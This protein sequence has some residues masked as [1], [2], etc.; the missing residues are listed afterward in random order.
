MVRLIIGLK[1]S[2]KTKNLIDLTNKAVETSPGNVVCVEK[3]NKL[4][5]DI[6]REVRLVDTD[7]YD[8]CTA[9]GLYGLICGIMASNYDVKDVFV[10]SGLRIIGADMDGF[11]KLI[12]RLDVL[13]G[14]HEVNL[15]CTVSIAPENL[16]EELTGYI[17]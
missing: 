2:G 17:Y 1:G 14:Q 12:K 3:G 7:E 16:P 6:K 10:D 4:I 5:H 13:T 11:V 8:I 9:N 15:V